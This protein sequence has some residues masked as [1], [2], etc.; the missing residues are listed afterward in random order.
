MILAKSRELLRRTFSDRHLQLK[1]VDNIDEVA[2]ES[3]E[4]LCL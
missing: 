2:E 3:C 1:V 4:T